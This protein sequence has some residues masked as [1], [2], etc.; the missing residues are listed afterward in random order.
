MN[1][2]D[3]YKVYTQEINS[4]QVRNKPY[5]GLERMVRHSE[6]LTEIN[7]NNMDEKIFKRFNLS[8]NIYKLIT[9]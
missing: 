7:V 5:W 8:K 2:I 9:I 6:E 3:E 4:E 1:K